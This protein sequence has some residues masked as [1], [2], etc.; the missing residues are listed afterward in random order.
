M[1]NPQGDKRDPLPKRE[2]LYTNLNIFRYLY[3]HN[4][5]V[6][7]ESFPAISC[8][9]KTEVGCKSYGLKKLAHGRP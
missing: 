9:Q 2:D 6:D 5:K 4:Q 3:Y 1:E 7:I 8:F